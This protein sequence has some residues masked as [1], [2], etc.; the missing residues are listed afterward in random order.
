VT[1]VGVL[2]TSLLFKI[3]FLGWLLSCIAVIW[4]FGALL[5]LVP[6]LSPKQLKK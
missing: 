5:Q 2:T 3:P 4:G 1:V 6:F